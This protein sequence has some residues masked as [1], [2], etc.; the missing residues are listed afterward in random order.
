VNPQIQHA[1]EGR[2]HRR[3]RRR[4]GSVPRGIIG[5]P[6][7]S[8]PS[9]AAAAIVLLA[10]I[11]PGCGPSVT[12]A[13]VAPPESPRPPGSA[14]T[15]SLPAVRFVDVTRE[16]GLAFVHCNAAAGEKLLPETMGSGM[17]VLDY[18]GDGDQD[19]FFVNSAPWSGG[20]QRDG[21]PPTQALYRN[22]GKGHFED[23]TVAAGLDRTFFGMGAAVGDYDNDGDPDLYVTTVGGGVLFRNDGGTFHDVTAEAGAHGPDGWLTG[24]AFFDLENDGDLDLFA[25][26]Y[27]SW[28]AASDR[29][30]DF[31]LT[32]G[33]NG[34]AYGLP[35]HFGGSSC[36]LFRNDGGHFADVSEQAGLRVRSPSG[37]P[38]A[39]ALGVA[40]QDVDGDGRVDLAVANDTAPNFF[41]HNLGGGTFEEIGLVSGVAFGQSDAARGAMG[42]D[43]AHFKG[44]RALGLA[45]GNFAGEMT[46]LY[47]ADDPGTLQ[48]T[49]LASLYGLGPPTQAPLTFGLFF[50]DYDL[51]GRPDLLSANGH[52]EPDIARV[53]AGQT[54]AQPA[55]LFRN[56]GR[57][58]R[59][60]FV[61]VGPGAAGPDLFRPIA[62]RGGAY[63]DVDGDGDLDVVLTANGQ[64]ARLFRNDGG[65]ANRWIRLKLTGRS[66][67]RDAIGAKVAVRVG[68]REL[69]QQLFP[70]RGYLSSVELPL[71]FGLGTAEKADRITIAWPAGGTTTLQDVPAGRL[72]RVDEVDGLR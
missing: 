61:P 16:A 57:P 56:T 10:S 37:V 44:D 5:K 6:S 58:G 45:I 34:R 15:E 68:D 46:A 55:Q 2:D 33:G 13:V 23:A 8:R 64:P 30:Q 39:K 28:T 27:V 3:P 7:S 41:F 43:W 59:T 66:S 21:P 32:A 70:A 18:D 54:Y 12:P 38:T 69:R 35:T 42:I 65:D 25:C 67:N 26:G 14:R 19:L 24:A 11:L 63:A 29:V 71:T 52:L 47:V 49:D 40:P 51:D 48:F 72:Y 50:F 1:G 20:G 31:H 36:V 4:I 17:A 22:D 53:Q 9:F 60:L 62:G